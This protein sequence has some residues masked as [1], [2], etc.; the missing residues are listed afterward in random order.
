MACSGASMPA[1]GNAEPH[2]EIESTDHSDE[3]LIDMRSDGIRP[4]ACAVTESARANG[5]LKMRLISQKYRFANWWKD[6]ILYL[7]RE[8]AYLDN[9]SKSE[10]N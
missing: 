2:M 8:S 3:I 10:G 7:R 5:A 1:I 4:K 6:G 9:C